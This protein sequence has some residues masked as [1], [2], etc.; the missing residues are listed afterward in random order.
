[1]FVNHL[2]RRPGHACHF[3]A[4][5]ATR[6]H[7]AA[8]RVAKRV[9]H[10]RSG[11]A[12]CI[13]CVFERHLP[14]VLVPRLAVFSREDGGVGDLALGLLLEEAERRRRQRNDAVPGLSIEGQRA[15]LTI[16]MFD[17]GAREFAGDELR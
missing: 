11:K 4:V 8:R 12:S 14:R 13:D 16:K 7:F 1:M 2:G 3:K 15:L 5:D 6:D 10:D 17:A 9:H